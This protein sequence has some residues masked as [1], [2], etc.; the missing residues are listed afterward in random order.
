MIQLAYTCLRCQS[1]LQ[2]FMALGVEVTRLILR[3]GAVF[4]KK[5]LELVCPKAVTPLALRC[6]RALDFFLTSLS[7][8][9]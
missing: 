3:M 7:L 5:G 1:L 2:S 6:N 8:R 4:S 9:P